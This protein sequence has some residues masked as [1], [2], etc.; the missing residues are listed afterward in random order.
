MSKTDSGDEIAQ[1]L[2]AFDQDARERALQQSGL[3]IHRTLMLQA[4][5]Q[6]TRHRHTDHL[7]AQGYDLVHVELVD[8]DGNK[9]PDDSERRE[10]PGWQFEYTWAKPGAEILDSVLVHLD[11]WQRAG[12]LDY[13]LMNRCVWILATCRD[14]CRIADH[15]STFWAVQVVMQP[16]QASLEKWPAE[17]EAEN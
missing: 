10:G 16:E 5:D 12:Q 7:L 11:E 6:E 4:A 13:L 8:Q 15:S 2:V 14:L 17:R 9:L 1:A 3:T